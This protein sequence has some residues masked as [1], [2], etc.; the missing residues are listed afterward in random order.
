MWSLLLTTISDLSKHDNYD[1]YIDVYAHGHT[2]CTTDS[3]FLQLANIGYANVYVSV[4]FYPWIS[5]SNVAL[6]MLPSDSS[7]LN[8]YCQLR[9]STGEFLPGFAIDCPCGV[10]YHGVNTCL[11]ILVHFVKSSF[12]QQ[13]VCNFGIAE[14]FLLFLIMSIHIMS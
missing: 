8:V 1:F 12:K 4:Y 6:N 7:T 13:L 2:V 9:Y 14:I 10:W 3:G 11:P 5:F